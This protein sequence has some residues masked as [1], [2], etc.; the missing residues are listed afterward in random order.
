MCERGVMCCFQP[1]KCITPLR[2]Q[3]KD[4][5]LG[6]VVHRSRPFTIVL[7][8]RTTEQHSC[9]AQLIHLPLTCSL[10][11]LRIFFSFAGAQDAKCYLLLLT[12]KY[13]LSF[14]TRRK[15]IIHWASYRKQ[16]TN[17]FSLIFCSYP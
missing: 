9:S 4:S 13:I 17:T 2:P 15:L 1:D 5:A 3:F 6:V 8:L 14:S 7:P 12:L 11:V 16:Y 10:L